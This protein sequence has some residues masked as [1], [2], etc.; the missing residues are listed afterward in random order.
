MKAKINKTLLKTV[1]PEIKDQVFWDT[2][3]KGFG[4]KIT[5][6]YKKV[7]IF[8]SRLLGDTRTTRFTIG[9]YGDSI[10]HNSQPKILTVALARQI[11]GIYRGKVKSGGD[12]KP[13][14]P[15]NT[16][17]PLI[18]EILDEFIDLHVKNL[19]DNT[20]GVMISYIE[21]V[22][23]PYFSGKKIDE[24]SKADIKRL[25]D[26]NKSQK[27]RANHIYAILS[28]F[29]NWC[30]QYEYRDEGTNPC[31]HIKKFNISSK[32]RYLTHVENERLSVVLK[33]ALDSGIESI[34]IVSAI[35]LLRL[36]GARRNEILASKWDYVNFENHTL[37]LPDSK[38]GKKTIFLN[39]AAMAILKEIPRVEGNEYII[40]GKKPECHLV[41]IQKAWSRIRKEAN[42]EDVRLHDLRHTFASIAVTQGK[43]LH[44]VGRLL[45]HKQASTTFKYAH[46][47][48]SALTEANNQI[49][50]FIKT[51]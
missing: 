29:L 12:P 42:I 10:I 28:K 21:K 1:K 9:E 13:K 23:K 44:L 35:N 8:Q 16:D 47:A 30:E 39:D 2:E 6:K 32:E 34:Y 20:S 31:R 50:G 7:F 5:P 36:T 14:T 22:I 41:N 17:N 37:V 11:A 4:L 19:K 33:H 46:L 45:G 24:I 3:I 48:P 27:C 43:S 38:T 40:V 18:S 26:T 51:T 25:Q 15:E 49:G